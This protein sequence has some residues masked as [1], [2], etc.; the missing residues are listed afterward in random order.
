MRS[1]KSL[2]N[3]EQLV[4]CERFSQL[5]RTRRVAYSKDFFVWTHA[6]PIPPNMA[7]RFTK[8]RPES[9]YPAASRPCPMTSVQTLGRQVQENREE[10]LAMIGLC[11]SSLPCRLSVEASFMP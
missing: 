11:P 3:V 8:L 5:K 7:E 4:V 10:I 6:W 1:P 9:S 2:G